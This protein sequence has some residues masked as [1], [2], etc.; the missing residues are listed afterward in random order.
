MVS[1]VDVDS[2]LAWKMPR[3]CSYCHINHHPRFHVIGKSRK[4]VKQLVAGKTRRP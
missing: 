4:E 1:K 3:Q 2:Q